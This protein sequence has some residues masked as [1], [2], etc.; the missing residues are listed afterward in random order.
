MTDPNGSPMPDGEPHAKKVCGA[1]TRGGTPCQQTRLGENGRC[2]MHGGT[3]LGG[4][5]HPNFKHGRHVLDRFIPKGLRASYDRAMRD[6]ELLSLRGELA[7]MLAMEAKVFKDMDCAEVPPW[8]KTVEALNDYK[9]ARTEAEKAEALANLETI[10]RT[11]AD[12]A[13][14]YED[15]ERKV[16][17]LFQERKDLVAAESK[18]LHELDHFLTK[19]Q[20][21]ALGY[22]VM[23]AMRT[24]VL[25]APTFAAGPGAVLRRA[26]DNLRQVL[27][28]PAPEE[29][30]G[31]V[32]IEGTPANG[33]PG[34]AVEGEP[35]P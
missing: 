20:A 31:V 14:S 34:D 16:R 8:G 22:L 18:R 4:L 24:A 2:R 9:T 12:A 5:A 29:P 21:T 3:A 26:Q 7:S 27:G 19:E 23:Q 13:K 30:A 17:R 32:T 6:T 28:M 35:T 15:L 1:K 25:D 11:G 10:I 33:T